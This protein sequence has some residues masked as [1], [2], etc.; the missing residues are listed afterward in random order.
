MFYETLK[1]CKVHTEELGPLIQRS[2]KKLHMY[3]VYCQNKPVS[4]HIVAENLA[5]FD[6]IRMKL[7]HKLVVS[8]YANYC[9]SLL[10]RFGIINNYTDYS[11]PVS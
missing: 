4:E 2:D 1:R 10:I 8:R 6:E 7:K 11:A 3:V 9:G 5:Y